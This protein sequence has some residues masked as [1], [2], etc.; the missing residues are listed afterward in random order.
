[1][2]ERLGYRSRGSSASRP[3]FRAGCLCDVEKVYHEDGILLSWWQNVKILTRMMADDCL[4]VNVPKHHIACEYLKAKWFWRTKSAMISNVCYL[5]EIGACTNDTAGKKDHPANLRGMS[6]FARRPGTNCAILRG[7]SQNTKNSTSMRKVS[8]YRPWFRSQPKYL[9][10]PDP[11]S[12]PRKQKSFHCGLSKKNINNTN[13]CIENLSSG[14]QAERF[15]NLC[16][17]KELWFSS[18]W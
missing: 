3:N 16:R 10:D 14:F 6:P 11:Q 5:E 1:M 18:I 4:L 17:S 2:V 9:L 15:L 13:H 12:S 8:A 7:I